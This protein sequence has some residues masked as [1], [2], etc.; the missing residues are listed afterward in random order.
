MLEKYWWLKTIKQLGP[1]LPGKCGFHPSY[2]LIELRKAFTSPED[3]LLG[4]KEVLLEEG[5][6]SHSSQIP[7]VFAKGASEE[8]VGAL[9]C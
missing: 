4:G 5:R 2:L 6:E 8:M 9:T 3:G 1:L 7:H